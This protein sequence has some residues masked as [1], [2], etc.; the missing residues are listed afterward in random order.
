MT[1]FED[2]L[3]A[4]G[5]AIDRCFGWIAERGR[6]SGGYRPR[7]LKGSGRSYRSD[8]WHREAA[9]QLERWLSAHGINVPIQNLARVAFAVVLAVIIIGLPMLAW[10]LSRPSLTA[11][12]RQE[13]DEM[14]SLSTSI[15]AQRTRS[16]QPG[17]PVV[18]ASKQ[19]HNGRR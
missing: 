16:L 4:L 19:T 18:P 12:T 14:A 8:A 6:A 11:P 13:Q 5:A 15:V 17:S 10:R 2:H 3:R 9:D 7:V 1:F